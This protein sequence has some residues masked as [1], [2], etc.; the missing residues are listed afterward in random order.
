MP[1]AGAGA[2]PGSWPLPGS[3]ASARFRAGRAEPAARPARRPRVTTGREPQEETSATCFLSILVVRPGRA[4]LVPVVFPAIVGG[5]RHGHRQAN[6]GAGG[7]EDPV[8]AVDGTTVDD[9]DQ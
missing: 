3:P 7:G 8:V 5:V 4:I 2:D 9:F 1:G 6:V